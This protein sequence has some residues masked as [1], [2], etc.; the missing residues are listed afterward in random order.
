MSTNEILT[1]F[2]AIVSEIA[3]VDASRVTPEKSF[4]DDLDLDSLT[5]VEVATAAE[6]QFSVRIPDGDLKHLKTVGDT[7]DYIA[8]AG[9][10][11]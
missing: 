2:A 1:G 10:A 3:G 4:A 6:D 11:A 8:K 5:M 7:V 9:V